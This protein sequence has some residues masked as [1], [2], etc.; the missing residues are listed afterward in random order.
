MIE[1]NEDKIK[2]VTTKKAGRPK[3]HDLDFTLIQKMKKDGKTDKE[4]YTE[5]GISKSLYYLRM[6]EYK[7]NIGH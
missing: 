1:V 2:E 4:I 5:L 6:K 7:N 3:E